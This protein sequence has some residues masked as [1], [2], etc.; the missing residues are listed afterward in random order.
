[1]WGMWLGLIEIRERIVA[2]QVMELSASAKSNGREE[3]LI[4]LRRHRLQLPPR[5][6]M[7]HA[8]LVK[9]EAPRHGILQTARDASCH[10]GWK[11]IR[12][13]HAAGARIGA[14]DGAD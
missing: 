5:Q 8:R 3:T 7:V 13:V 11:H 10:F 12:Y 4:R 6:F 9:N 14:S 2:I 1:M